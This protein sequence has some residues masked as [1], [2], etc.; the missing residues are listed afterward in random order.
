MFTTDS[1]TINKS[2]TSPIA[3]A[4]Q[5]T[6]Y[7]DSFEI[8]M[9]SAFSLSIQLNGSTPSVQVVLQISDTAPAASENAADTSNWCQQ[10]GGA[11]IYTALTDTILHKITLAPTVSRY[12][13]LQLI[14]NSGNG[15]NVTVLAKLISQQQLGR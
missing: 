11:P 10:D 2:G 4:S 5:A 6:V 15:A 3:V 9:A 12:A 1:K 14:G 7:T 13:R 8:G